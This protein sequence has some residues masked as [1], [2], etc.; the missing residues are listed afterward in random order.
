MCD[1]VE[2]RWWPCL[3]EADGRLALE[4][5]QL[6]DCLIKP[7]VGYANEAMK[8]VGRGKTR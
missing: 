5:S 3:Q 8:E 7:G 4:L 2:R 1:H 6:S